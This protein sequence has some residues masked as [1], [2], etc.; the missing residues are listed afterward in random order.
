[1]LFP[2]LAVGAVLAMRRSRPLITTVLTIVLVV[3]VLAL[4][5]SLRQIRES[6]IARVTSADLVSGPSSGLAEMG[7]SIK[8]VYE[9][10]VW[11]D[12]NHEPR[13]AGTTYIEPSTG[14]EVHPRREPAECGRG[15]ESPGGGDRSA[16]GADRWVS[17]R[18]S[19]LQLRY[20]GCPGRLVPHRAGSRGDREM[21]TIRSSRCRLRRALR[22][23]PDQCSQH[24]RTS[25][26][27]ARLRRSGAGRHLV[28]MARRRA[29]L[30]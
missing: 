2:C 14:H 20:D 9:T 1:V 19:V 5:G 10:L 17:G 8:P 16:G 25:S 18:R 11:A 27:R 12:V 6:G 29:L 21:E 30:V 7:Y 23:P 24:V 22:R 15:H 28:C 4:I 26:G 3:G 13:A